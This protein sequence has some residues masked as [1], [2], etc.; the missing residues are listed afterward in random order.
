MHAFSRA[1][2]LWIEDEAEH[3]QDRGHEHRPAAE[4]QDQ[5]RIGT[6]SVLRRPVVSKLRRRGRVGVV[7][8]ALVKLQAEICRETAALLLSAAFSMFV[9]SL[10]LV[11]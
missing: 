4:E 6:L 8:G 7:V 10:S 5:M 3:H 11:K 2:V 9:P 1:A